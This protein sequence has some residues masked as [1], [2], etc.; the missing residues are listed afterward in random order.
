MK[1]ADTLSEYGYA[2]TVLYAYWNAWGTE[3]DKELL[4][5]KKWNAIRV[6]GDPV[7]QPVTYFISRLIYKA[8][9]LF[10]Q[11]TGSMLFADIAIARSSFFLIR[12]A[13][14]HD[15][16]LYTGH[17]LGALPAIVKAAKKHNKLCAFDAEDFHRNEVTDD[18]YSMHVKLT[19]CI[20]DRYIPH[21]QY[22]T[23]SSPLIREKYQQ[24]YPQIKTGTILNTFSKNQGV[25]IPQAGTDGAVRL[26]WFSQTI[27]NNRGLEDV[28]GAMMILKGLP[29]ELHLLGHLPNV[30]QTDRLMD[31]IAI[32]GIY[33]RVFFYDPLPPD[34]LADFASRFDIGLALEPGFCINNNLALSNKIFTYLQAGLSVIASDTPAQSLL[35]SEYP[36]IGALY[37]KGDHNEL[38]QVLKRWLTDRQLLIASKN[39]AYQVGQTTLN[40]E[41]E[42]SELLNLVKNT[43]G[44]IE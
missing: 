31:L 16:D 3:L 34:E 7:H 29:L 12:E 20:E 11:K 32:A 23:A 39:E 18:T 42:G 44:S 41:N 17:N 33:E 26:F 19:T 21:L 27:G 8:A 35:L 37:K 40:W 28:I 36:Q 24:L 4:S 38:A 22:L 14:N 5:T 2:V 6:G 43:L 30:P 25:K 13:K 15:A 10:T 1:E 9:R